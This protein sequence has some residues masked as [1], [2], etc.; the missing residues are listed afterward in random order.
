MDLAAR[1]RRV[2]CSIR[3]PVVAMV[4]GRR[5][6]IEHAERDDNI[7][8]FTISRDDAEA[9]FVIRLP[10]CYS[11]ITDVDIEQINSNGMCMY[12]I[13]RRFC[14]HRGIPLLEISQNWCQNVFGLSTC[15]VFSSRYNAR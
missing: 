14:K 9:L 13:Y 15:F 8:I 12:I 3:I 6:H 7:V 5:Y 4:E 1:F 11:D 2:A 10:V